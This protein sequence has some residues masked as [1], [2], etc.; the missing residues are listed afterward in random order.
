M[1]GCVAFS[2]QFIAFIDLDVM[3]KYYTA[4]YYNFSY[5]L[6]LISNNAVLLCSYMD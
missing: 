4:S 1:L 6:S 3:D 2:M 5:G